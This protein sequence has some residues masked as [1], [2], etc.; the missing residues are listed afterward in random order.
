MHGLHQGFG[1]I[2]P[3]RQCLLE[4]GTGRLELALCLID[5]PG[6]IKTERLFGVNGLNCGGAAPGCGKIL[7]RELYAKSGLKCLR[8]A[9]LVGDE[10]VDRWL[11]L[12]RLTALDQQVRELQT[13]RDIAWIRLRGLAQGFLGERR[14]L[15]DQIGAGEPAQHDRRVGLITQ[16]RTQ[17]GD[18]GRG[19]AARDGEVGTHHQ[20]L[21]VARTGS[22]HFFKEL[23]SLG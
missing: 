20:R 3:Q 13:S 18:G 22:K 1:D 10:L 5:Q 12:F 15:V 17:I 19:I 2:R 7:A 14:V 9:R 11:C 23:G 21:V 4:I 6:K 16:H 8:T